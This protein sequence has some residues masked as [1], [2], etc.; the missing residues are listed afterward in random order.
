MS[1]F[2]DVAKYILENLED[3]AHEF[4]NPHNLERAGKGYFV[5]SCPFCGH[6]DCFSLTKG[7]NAGKCFSCDESGTLIQ[8]VQKIH[9]EVEGLQMLA[10][11]TGKPYNFAS[12]NPEKAAE[13]ERHARFQRICHKAI[14]FYHQRLRTVKVEIDEEEYIPALYQKDVRKHKRLPNGFILEKYKVGYSGGFPELKKSLLAEGYTEEEIDE[15]KKLIFLPDGYFIYP[16]YDMKGNLVRINARAFIRYCRGKQKADGHGYH[17]D[18]DYATAN[19]KDEQ[20][21]LHESMHKH[22]MN[23]DRL[24]RGDKDGVFLFHPKDLQNKKKKYLILVEGENDLISVDEALLELAE[25]H[26]A[27]QTKFMVSAIGGNAP[28]GIFEAE[29]L[30]QFDEVYEAFDNDEAGEKYREQLD[31]EMPDVRL[32]HIEIPADFNDIDEFLKLTE[33]SAELFKDMLD[34]AKIQDTAN[35][36]I[37]RDF[38][39]HHWILENRQQSL[40]YE[41]DYYDHQKKGFSGTLLLFRGKIQY[42]KKVGDIDKIKG[43]NP[44]QNRLKVALSTKMQSYYHE[45]RWQ[46][47]G[48]EP[49]RS[50]D[51]LLDIFRFTKAKN[52]VSKQIAWYLFHTPKKDYEAKVREVQLKIRKETDVADIIREVNGYENQEIDPFGNFP[53]IQLA[54]SFFPA[55]GD[56]YMYFVKTIKDGETAKRVPCLITNKKEEIRLDLLKKKTNQSLLLIN[57]KYELPVE[58]ETNPVEVEDLSLQ[59]MWVHRWRKG[60]LE[61]IEI[62]P[63]TIIREIEAFIR[64]TYYTTDDIIKVLALWIYATYFY[65]LFKNGFP[66]MVFNGAKGTGKSTLDDIVH[67]LAFNPT[68]SVS[69]SGP[70]LYRTVA[71]FGGTF[72]LDEQENMVESS[73]VNESDLAAVIKAGYSDKGKVHRWNNDIGFAEGFSAFGPKVISNIN[74]VEDVIADRCIQINTY[75]AKEEHLSKLYDTNIFKGERRDEVYSISSRAAISALTH[76][77]RVDEVFR[78]NTRVDTGNARLTQ[79]LRP[80][81]TIARVVGGDYEDH[82]MTFYK[83]EVQSAKADIALSTLE[84]KIKYILMSISEE[85]LGLSKNKWIIDQT[86][87]FPKDIIV[88]KASGHFEVDTIQFKVLAEELADNPADN[89]LKKDINAAVKNVMGKKFDLQN[90]RMMTNITVDDEQLIRKLNSRRVSGYR[91]TFNVREFIT[92]QAQRIQY[93]NQQAT[94][95]LF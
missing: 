79:I 47:N 17:Y 64:S 9:G 50:F 42:D 23:P 91:Y 1:W 78:T 95:S 38:P 43:L 29:F 56:G 74:G 92:E 86:H 7:V 45:I 54:Q 83:S 6:N 51:E 39:Q 81:V 61:D 57:N 60:E 80:L 69:I 8:I 85:I 5:N 77:K 13:K 75:A 59:Y 62:E 71:I 33:G 72:I 16:Y 24:S 19:L 18:C 14:D 70:A 34:S 53:K 22:S 44:E 27:Y 30:R 31:R 37:R 93:G 28:Q 46:K 20:K 21:K 82:L 49:H 68:F 48:E 11:W 63:S 40:R 10:E 90:R 84:G 88:D 87:A 12:H 36:R 58:I 67:L 65:T 73:K 41:I 32:K 55:N 76:F 35:F 3:Y 4:L 25:E 26:P 15:A 94:E 89:Y 66:Y 52:D 2:D